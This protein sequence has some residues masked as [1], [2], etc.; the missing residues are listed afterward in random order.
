MSSSGELQTQLGLAQQLNDLFG[1]W[2]DKIKSFGG[3]LGDQ[4]ETM[5]EMQSGLNDSLES[6]QERVESMEEAID[7]L[8]AGADRAGASTGGM[9]SKLGKLGGALAIGKT[10]FSSFTSILS[11]TFSLLGGIVKGFLNIGSAIV[12]TLMNAWSG[13]Q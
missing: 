11:G 8:A 13:L 3:A 1:E 10:M 5:R 4:T 2:A 9:T 7:R 12:G 6:S